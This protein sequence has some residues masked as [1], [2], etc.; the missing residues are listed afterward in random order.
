MRRSRMHAR[1]RASAG[2]S[3]ARAPVRGSGSGGG[4]AD[5][6]TA[7][8][9]RRPAWFALALGSTAALGGLIRVLWIENAPFR[10][11]GLIVDEQYY[12][13]VA[14][15]VAHGLGYISPDAFDAGSHQPSAEKPPL[16]PL[17]LALESKLGFSSFQSHR[18]L[19]AL[20]GMA[21]IVLLA[22]LARRL[23]G[24]RLGLITGLLVALDPVLWK[25]DSQ[26]L[27]EPLYAPLV[28]LILLAAYAVREKPTLRNGALLGLAIGFAALTRPEALMFVPLLVLLFLFQQRSAAVR[29]LAAACLVTALVVSP[30]IV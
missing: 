7:L 10:P 20:L 23:G 2:V 16:Y 26:V 9:G 22:L 28:A 27:S 12:H 14:N 3:R 11:G 8:R 19:G 25:W 15:F 1:R 29:P 6:L 4:W 18:L 21:T 17:I 13:R 24:E 5:A 30:W